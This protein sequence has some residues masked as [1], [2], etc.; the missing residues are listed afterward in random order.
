LVVEDDPA[1]RKTIQR[2]LESEGYQV[3]SAENVDK[4]CG[5]IGDNVDVVLSDLMLEEGEKSPG[6]AELLRLWKSKSPET[7][8]ILITGYGGIGSAVECIKAGAFHYLTKPVNSDELLAVLKRACEVQHK[9]RQLDQLRERLDEKFDLGNIVGNSPGM[10]K[11][12]DLIKRAGQVSS[13][14]LILGESGTGKE[15]VAQALH[16]NSSRKNGPYVAVNCAPV[17]ANLVESE[18]FGHVRGAF[19]GATDR[20]IGRFEQANGGTLLIDEIGDMDLPLQA[21]LL[22]VLETMK[23]TPV[24]GSEEKSVDVR[25][26]AATSRK[27]AEMVAEGRFREDLFGRLKVLTI[28]LPSLRDRRE[29]IPLLV[30]RFL[31]DIGRKNNSPVRNIEPEAMA[32]LQAYDWPGNVRELKNAIERIMVFVDSD[33][34]TLRDLPED[35]LGNRPVGA[36]TP[37]PIPV[38][39]SMDDLERAAILE[40]LER[41]NG[42]RTHAARVLGISVRTLQRKLKDYAKRDETARRLQMQAGSSAGRPPS[43]ATVIRSAVPAPGHAV[44]VASGVA[45]S[46]PAPHAANSHAATPHGAAPA[47]NPGPMSAPAPMPT[48]P[49]PE[50]PGD[51]RALGPDAAPGNN[52]H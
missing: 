33:T 39:L 22:R 9:S 26:V 45:A 36:P 2:I 30:K 38:G 24:G 18:L 23:V 12:F 40:A 31:T 14:V 35:I 46:A 7:E 25:V 52:G 3:Y 29:D 42:N 20:R 50:P 32:R 27:L 21:K 11:V 4:A 51:P 6:G 19:T 17:P 43:P 1:Q 37:P 10:R 15:L 41:H 28:D 44:P 5:Y 34:I 8:F 49:A 16:Q 47:P 48:E 13:T